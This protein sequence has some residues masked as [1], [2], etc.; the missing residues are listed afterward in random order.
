MASVPALTG[1]PEGETELPKKF[2]KRRSQ[3]KHLT[4]GWIFEN[5]QPCLLSSRICSRFPLQRLGML[6]TTA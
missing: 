3:Q 6:R 1:Y 2:Y 4:F 5:F